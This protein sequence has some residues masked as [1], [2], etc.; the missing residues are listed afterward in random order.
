M[1][2]RFPWIGAALLTSSCVGPLHPSSPPEDTSPSPEEHA[3]APSPEG[4]GEDET[5]RPAPPQEAPTRPSAC[6][7]PPDRP[8]TPL[9][10]L[11]REEYAR[12]LADLFGPSALPDDL[13]EFDT[14]ERAVG[15][16]INRD[17]APTGGQVAL[18]LDAAREVSGRVIGE[19][20][21]RASCSPEE[22]SCAS[23]FVETWGER[24]FRRP[25]GTDRGPLLELYE[26]ARERAGGA[27]ALEAVLT[28]MLASP[29]FLYH[30]EESSEAAA[31]PLLGFARAARLSFFL[32]G[33]TPDDR[34][35]EAA[36]DGRLDT[37][38]GYRAEVD[39][40]LADRARLADT[41][42]GF[43]GQYLKTYAFD[44]LVRSSERFPD[45]SD[46]LREDY[47]AEAGDFAVDVLLAQERPLTDL[48]VADHTVA[49]PAATELYGASDPDGD[50]RSSL[51]GTPRTA[52]ILTLGAFLTTQAH[53]NTV[54]W[55]HRG[56]WIRDHL[57]CEGV[58]PPPP[59]VDDAA[60]DA[61]AGGRVEN[62]KCSA[63]HRKL[64]PLGKAFDAFDS[65]G[66]H[67][68]IDDFGQSVDTSGEV[69]DVL[70][71]PSLIGP[72][73]GPR[74]LATRLAS[75]PA[76]LECMATH[77]LR[78]ALRRDESGSASDRCARER[79]AEHLASDATL[80]GL[81]RTIASSEAFLA[82]GGL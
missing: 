36:R 40:L 72:F 64:D 55:V 34:L 76:V 69:L 45:W 6:D 22:L 1:A 56:L 60:E 47:L 52:G 24:V 46:T 13:L 66:K 20:L 12:T 30:V 71:D 25:L 53:E 17:L 62:P 68:S 70:S 21:D 75:S 81:L 32:W 49:G 3:G 74:E 27:A 78:L 9:L 42:S 11:T 51:T 23:S 43:Y 48:L 59:D 82:S 54:S 65:I 29:H 73:S 35:L 7:A 67:R 44:E 10:R 79:L 58:P 4:E 33:T 80:P 14:R 77:W 50:G 41:V 37:D 61:L 19:L 18:Y 26:A 28:A 15:F 57:L 8:R 63:C 39:R 31:G 2:S 5:S 16:Q 38:S